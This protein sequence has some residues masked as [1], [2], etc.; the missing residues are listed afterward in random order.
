M[1]FEELWLGDTV[2]DDV[3]ERP[4]GITPLHVRDV[5]VDSSQEVK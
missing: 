4:P 1:G 3:V 5:A 2:V